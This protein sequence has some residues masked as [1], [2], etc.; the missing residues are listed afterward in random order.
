MPGRTSRPTTS[1]RSTVRRSTR[2]SVTSSGPKAS[3]TRAVLSYSRP[4]SFSSTPRPKRSRRSSRCC[5]RSAIAPPPRRRRAWICVTGPCSAAARAVAN[6]PG[7]PTPSSLNDVLAEL[8]RLHGDLQFR[9]IGT[10]ALTSDSGQQGEVSGM[11]L[12]VEQTAFVQGDTLNA[13]I[14]MSLEGRRSFVPI[15]QEEFQL[16]SVEVRTALR[17]GEFV[18]LGQSDR[19]V[20]KATVSQRGRR[21]GL[22]HR[23]LARR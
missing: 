23:A 22:L 20:G 15:D 5:K 21:S 2:R 3:S 13:T 17:R 6:P 16:G 18:V 14:R 8:E 9:V 11:T 7:T 4:D 10:A 12:E 19:V 1:I